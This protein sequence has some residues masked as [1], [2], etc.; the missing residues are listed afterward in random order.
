MIVRKLI[1]NDGSTERELLLGS[2]LVVGRDPECQLHDM[3]P[4]LSRRHAEFVSNPQGVIIRD[5]DSRNGIL[6]NGN[7]VPHHALRPGDVVQLGHLNLRYIEETV[8]QSADEHNRSHATTATAAG[9]GAPRARASDPPPPTERMHAMTLEP[10][11]TMAPRP[12]VPAAPPP[13]ATHAS[14]DDSMDATRVPTMAAHDADATRVP[15][16]A[17]AAAHDA[18][19]TRVPSF[20][21]TREPGR[22][23]PPAPPV[24]SPMRPGIAT[25]ARIIANGS[26]IIT[27]ASHNCQDVIGTRPDT[28]LGGRLA[29]ALAR[30][31]LFVTTGD[32]PSSLNLSIARSETSSF[33]TVT[34]RAG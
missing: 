19:A 16:M 6:V 30:A 20:D 9:V 33:I 2:T 17:A 15:T 14:A 11:E 18:D 28:I 8:V 34:F 10:D 12:P 3:D 31:L 1:V 21:E 32:G 13:P 7:K 4:L 24:A 26:G 27:E 23:Q 25:E 5:L 22:P 29:D